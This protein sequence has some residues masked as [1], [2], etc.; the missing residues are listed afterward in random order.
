MTTEVSWP[1]QV[2]SAQFGKQHPCEWSSLYP[3][4]AYEAVLEEHAVVV[5][6]ILSA[7]GQLG[8]A[9]KLLGQTVDLCRCW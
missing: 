4:S 2:A 9:E 6:A 8:L 7:V 1:A 3:K 5:R